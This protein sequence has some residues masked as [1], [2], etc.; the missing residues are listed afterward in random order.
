MNPQTFAIGDNAK[1]VEGSFSDF[2][3]TIKEVRPSEGKVR[4]AISIFG[5]S[6]SIELNFSQIRPATPK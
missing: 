4:V 6:E 1:I 2:E 3:G 5:R